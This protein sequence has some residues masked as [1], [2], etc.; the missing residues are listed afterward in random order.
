MIEDKAE[1][2]ACMPF[3]Y[4]DIPTVRTGRG[5]RESLPRILRL[6]TASGKEVKDVCP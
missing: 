1:S 4:C 5:S 6:D 3:P 2:A